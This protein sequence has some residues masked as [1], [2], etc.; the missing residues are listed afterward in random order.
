V[1]R[2]RTRIAASR[3]RED[4]LILR[5]NIGRRLGFA[6]IAVLLVVALFVG[7]DWGEDFGRQSVGGTIFY[8]LLTLTTLGVAAWGRSVHLDKAAGEVHQVRTLVGIEVHRT[9][10]AASSVKAVVIQGMRFLKEAEQPRPGLLNTRFRNYVDRRNS[11]YKLFLERDDDRIFLEDSTDLSDLDGAA[12]QIS[13]FMG[14]TLRRE[15][16]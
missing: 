9:T 15:D 7:V 3:P 13:G 1:L 11:Y 4:L 8:L 5:S 12:E 6:A 10:T 16:I 14:I 2:V